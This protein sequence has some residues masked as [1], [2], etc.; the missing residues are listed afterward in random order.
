MA[1]RK[2]ALI[3]AGAAGMYC[4]SCI[5][6]NMLVLALR[7]QGHDA[8]LLPTYTPIRTD[9]T[10]VSVPRVFM[11][12]IN[13]YLQQKFPLFRHFPK[14][15][16]R[17]M[18]YPPLLKWVSR[19][20][21]STKAE[22]LG[23]LTISML[24]AQKGNQSSEVADLV[25]WLQNHFKPDIVHFSNLLLSGLAG[26][27]K[28]ACGAKI[29]GTL[30]G[31]DIFLESLPEL[32][33]QQAIQ[34]IRENSKAF[35]A[36]SATS[37]SYADR[38][39]SY[40]GLEREKISTI[41][42]GIEIPETHGHSQAA[43]KTIGYF[44]R[45]C[46]EKGFHLLVDAW[47]GM[48]QKYSHSGVK[49]KASGWLGQNQS[50]FFQQQ[51][52]K[53]TE[54]N[55]AGDFDYVR[56]TNGSSKSSFYD[57]VDILSVPSPYLEPKGLYVLEA[58]SHGVPVLQPDHGS[59]PEL[60][61]IAGGGG[62]LFKANQVEDLSEKLELVFQNESLIKTQGEI[63]RLAVRN[64]FNSSRMAEQVNTLYSSLLQP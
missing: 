27:I 59:F 33:R 16:K 37:T 35:D 36:F 60:L 64:F 13:V 63:G 55:L 9:E 19:F 32:F 18:D 2:I 52:A 30:Q 62:W 48:R 44:A 15:L 57:S 49:L 10:D 50:P 41:L 29:V 46:P 51:L 23:D 43:G 4:G 20:A 1:N 22:E 31:D 12:G 54:A 11:G 14:W 8:I 5:Q 25:H 34:L 53:I 47:I 17:L 24:G 21:V 7:R 39:S 40:L 42:P 61:E 56:C 26:P 28:D 3:T 6:D 45:I 38:M 58:W